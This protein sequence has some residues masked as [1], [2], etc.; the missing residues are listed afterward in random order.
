MLS[1]IPT[2][3]ATTAKTGLTVHN[4]I[5]SHPKT[6][7]LVGSTHQASYLQDIPPKVV[8]KILSLEYVEMAELLP[9]YWGAQGTQVSLL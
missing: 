9:E 4:A 8:K 5:D 1:S 2:F 6:A 3:Q 7:L